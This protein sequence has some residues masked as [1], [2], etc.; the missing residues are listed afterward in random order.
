MRAVFALALALPL[1]VGGCSPSTSGEVPL[2]RLTPTELQHTVR[3][4]LGYAPGVDWTEPVP[5]PPDVPI[6]GFE[7]M[8]EGQVASSYLVEQYAA[9]AA[10]FAPLALDAPAF[11]ACDDRSCSLD[12]VLRFA[13]RAYRRPLIPDEE[14]RLREF[15][16]ANVARDGEDEGTVATVAGILQ[17]PQFLYLMER[18]ALDDFAV[19][20]RLSYFLW[21]SMPDPQLFEAAAAGRLSRPGAV[22]REARRMLE[23]PRARQAVVHFHRQWLGIDEV[24]DNRASAAAYAPTWLPSLAEEEVWSSALIGMQAAMVREADLFVERT[25]F[26]S[27]GRLSDLLTDHH[28]HASRIQSIVPFDT[29]RLYGVTAADRLPRRAHVTVLDDDNLGYALSV[30]PVTL[31]ADQRAGVLGLG[32]V[33]AGRAHPVHPAPVLRGVFVLERLLCENV[34]QPPDDAALQAPPDTLAADATNRERL[35]AVTS[36]PPCSGCHQRI[37]PLGL[38][39]EHYDSL[40]GW[41]DTDHGQPVDASGSIDLGEGEVSFDGAVELASHLATSARAHDCYALHWTRYALGTDVPD[42]DPTLDELQRRFRTRHDGK[43]LELLVDLATSDAFLAR[44]TK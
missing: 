22:E 29:Y 11:W 4:L 21:D 13:K 35:E 32:A 16:A 18:P 6:H 25:V 3:D 15:H 26:E 2:R 27:P 19:A 33:L 23:D 1:Q 10:H 17:A 7:G 28:G 43:V 39:F 5:L 14:R 40:G 30:E 9:A 36:A 42:G 38:A 12:S 37:N 8:A 34:G 31:P 24:F 20:A 44:R 41:R